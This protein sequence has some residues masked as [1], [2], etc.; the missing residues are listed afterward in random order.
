MRKN[1]AIL[2]AGLVGLVG[3]PVAA[4][5]PDIFSSEIP[6]VSTGR[7]VSPRFEKLG[8]EQGLSQ[9]SILDMM[10]DRHGFMW[11]G[12]QDGLNRFDGY[13]VKIYRNVPFDSTS[14]IEGWSSALAEDADGR[15]WVATWSGKTAI[16]VM[17][18][19]TETFH[20]YVHDPADSTTVT[21]ARARSLLFDRNGALWIAFEQG[22]VDRMDPASPGKFTHFRYDEEDSTSLNTDWAYSFLEDAD[23]D[24]WVGTF[25]GLARFVPST[26]NPGQGAFDRYLEGRTP[27]GRPSGDFVREMYERPE[28]PGMLWLATGNGLIRFDKGTGTHTRYLVNP[29]DAGGNRVTAVAPDPVNRGVLWVTVFGHGIARFD[30]RAQRFFMYASDPADPNG[31]SDNLVHDIMTDRSGVIW[32]GADRTAERFNPSKVGFEYIRS[33]PS[34][35]ASMAGRSIWGLGLDSNDIL[36]VGAQR[37]EDAVFEL[38]AIDRGMSGG[39]VATYE[40]DPN[41]PYSVP[42]GQINK[43]L[44]DRTGVIWVASSGHNGAGLARLHRPSGRFYR[45]KVDPD[46][47]NALSSIHVI[48]LIEDRSGSVWIA[49]WGG[50]V[51]RWDPANPDVFTRFRHEASDSTSIASDRTLFLMEDQAG[52]IWVSSTDGVSRIDPLTG[53]ASSFRHD[54][55]NPR[56]LSSNSPLALHERRR[57]PGI[58]WVGATGLNRLDAASGQASH[59]TVAD[60]L[61]NNT[62]YAIL[63]DE[64]GRLWMST[65]AG[66]SRFD[67][68]TETFRNYGIEVGLQSLE[69][70]FRAGLRAESGEM[71]FGGING[72]NSFFP[73]E[74]I[75]SSVPPEVRLVDLKVGGE[76][77]R[78]NRRIRLDEPIPD[79]EEIRLSHE[80]KDVTF[81]FVGFHY[82]HPEQNRFSYKLEGYNDD[83]VN[84]GTARS[85]PYTNLPPGEYTFRVRAANHAGV[86]SE[87]GASIRVIISPPFWATWWFRLLA[88]FGTGGVLYLGYSLRMRQIAERTRALESEVGRRTAELQE[89]TR[90]LEM[91]NEHLEQSHTIVEAINQETSFSRLLTKILE[92]ARVIPGVEKATALIR[93]SD[94]QFHVRASSG[95]NVD[96]MKHIRL[97]PKQAHLRYIEQADEVGRN[98]FVAK[99]VAERAGT[100][101]MAEF[102]QVASF[103]VLRIVV[104]G[105]VRAYLVFDNLTNP[106]AFDD[107]DVALLE[108]LREHIQSAFI[109]TR[110]LEDLQTT[111]HN[112]RSTQDRLVQSEKMAS[113]GQLTA[114]IAHE[115]KNPLNFVN[116]FSDVT[117][118]LAHDLAEELAS[119]KDALPPEKA[120]ELE[121]LLEGLVLNAKK[122]AEHGKRADGIVQNMLEHSKIGE[123][124]RT[125]TDLN[126]LLDEYLTLAQH[127]LRTRDGDF[128][129]HVERHLGEAVGKVDLVPQDMGRVFM[130]LISNAFDALREQGA[131]NPSPT[132][133][134]STAVVEGTGGSEAEIRIADNGPGIPEHVKAKIFEPFFT[135]KPTG[136]GTGLGLS[137]SYDIVTK[138]HGGSLEVESEPGKGATFIV[139]LPL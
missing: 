27:E 59:Y 21:N 76:T 69:F 23:G 22:G 70:N 63:E 3:R 112:L 48:D 81:D 107:R 26:E 134:V 95:W 117:A 25:N 38:L 115:I 132:L 58:I 131:E 61:P 96:E 116:N 56:S 47:P 66:L 43:V 124:Q 6:D 7:V 50:G 100:E 93:Q 30:Q 12:T 46:D 106:D 139:R 127:G 60:G 125:S 119:V 18:P 52:F 42:G 68:E 45:F 72:L 54:P 28:E 104:E 130:N 83:W 101:E 73:N 39:L 87:E 77:V 129:V 36:W 113:L 90:R 51:L 137:M 57:E 64:E 105:D 123:G 97:S 118:E 14:L 82:E 15:L 67:P 74:L 71:F 35:H 31:L 133:A 94:D 41:D 37:P 99:D 111:L 103:L 65:N 13:E 121:G 2:V 34:D 108:R 114:G 89:S 109:K 17:D 126:D 85:A 98:I 40:Y 62:V 75:D 16:N 88:L 122:I 86:W 8:I 55:R 120:E 80:Q 110:I 136:S 5:Q 24:I 138:G 29:D 92:E 32:V 33:D 4:Q 84:A 53:K 102:G 135:T 11:F 19:V 10:Q 79:L 20:A 49:S 1:T 44:E 78:T 128:D 9:S 91:T